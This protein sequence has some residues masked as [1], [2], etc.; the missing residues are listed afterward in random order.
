MLVVRPRA[1]SITVPTGPFKDVHRAQSRQLAFAAGACNIPKL[2]AI[3]RLNTIAA[4]WNCVVRSYDIG[5][6]SL[7]IDA[8]SKWTDN[9]LSQHSIPDVVSARRGVARRIPYQ[10]LVRIALIRQLHTRFGTSVADAVRLA[11]QLLDLDGT[12]VHESGQ[13]RLIVDRA[14]LERVLNARLG[15]VL[16]SAPAIRRGRPPRRGSA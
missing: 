14:D 3:K 13:L 15:E 8:P 7:T 5:V 11:A 4:Q 16:E 6:A 9:L 10:A 2:L 12:G 1:A